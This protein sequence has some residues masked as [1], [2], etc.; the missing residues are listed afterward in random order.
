MSSRGP[1]SP[2]QALVELV[3]DPRDPGY[4]EA[5]ARRGSRRPHSAA[6]GWLTALG[7]LVIG[8]ALAVAWVHTHRSAPQAVKVHQGL[9]ERVRKA[10][11]TAAGLDRQAAG[12]GARLSRLRTRALSDSSGLQQQLQRLQVLA[13]ALPV[14]GPGVEVTLGEPSAKT[15]PSAAPTRGASIATILTDRD[16]RSVVNQLWSDGAE[17]VA[18][19]GIRLTPLSA[20]RFAGQAVLVDL[21]PITSPY[22]IDAI[23]DADALDTGFAASSVASRYLTLQQADGIAFGFAEHTSLQLPAAAVPALRYASPEP[24]S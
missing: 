15:G 17:A 24:G 13:G 11:A 3:L 16:V 22:R 19:N 12:L 23:G 7:C 8:F 18:V 20:I 6:D 21:E 9:V 4:E 1:A 10:D 5:A 2:T 14:S